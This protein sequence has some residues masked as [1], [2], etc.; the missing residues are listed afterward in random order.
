MQRP[1]LYRSALDFRSLTVASLGALLL[2]ACGEPPLDSPAGT[3][4][5]MTAA[6]LAAEQ[7]VDREAICAPDS[8]EL[9]LH[10]PSPD[11]GEQVVYM[12]F[13]DRFNDGD[14]TN[15]DFGEGEFDPTSPSHFN[16]GDI[17]GIIDQLDYIQGMGATAIWITPPVRN[18]WWSTPYRA[19]GWH[20]YWAQHFKEMDP[21]FGTLEEYQRLSHE[22]HCRGMYLVQDIVI[23]HVGNYYAYD[24]EWNPDDPTENFYLIEE[25]VTEPTAPTQEPFNLI[26]P[27]IPEH[28]EADIYHWTPQVTDYDDPYQL[29]YFGF[30]FLA[31][32]NT[33]NTVV[34]EAFKDSYNY[35]IREVGVDGF[36][37]DTV[38]YVKQP[39]WHHFL[40]DE[41]GV[42]AAAAETGREFFI[43]FGETMMASEP[44]QTEGEDRNAYFMDYEG[45][46]GLNSMLGFPLYFSQRRV[47]SEGQPAAQL[48]FRLEKHMTAYPDPRVIPTFIDNHDTARFIAT[49]GIEAFRQALVLVYT[50][51]GLP[52]I[53]M[54]TEQK[55]AETRH[56]MFAEGWGAQGDNFATDS[57]GYTLL[58]TLGGLRASDPLFTD[59]ELAV[60][61]GETA[62]PGLLAYRRDFDGRQV[63]VLMNSADHGILVHELETGLPAETRLEALWA[64]GAIDTVATGRDGLLSLELPARAA[65][66]LRPA[67]PAETIAA[68]V[69]VTPIA[70]DDAP[71]DQLLTADTTLTGTA[72]PDT[73]LKVIPD[74]NLDKATRVTT[75]SEGRF[76]LILPVRDL[77]EA[78]RSVQLRDPTAGTVSERITYRT[79][80]SSPTLDET[81]DDAT[82]EGLGPEGRYVI[83][84]H[85]ESRRQR[86]IESI[87]VRAAGRN[88]E[89]ELTM[90]EVSTPWSPI[91]GFD[92]VAVT[93]FIGFPDQAGATVLPLLNAHMPEGTHWNLAHATSGW[94]SYVYREE[95][96]SADHQGARQ[97]FAPRVQGDTAARTIT[98]FLE[99]ARLGVDDWSG[100]TLYVTTWDMNGEGGYIEIL[101]E[102][103]NW[104]FGGGQP[105]DPKIADALL[106]TLPAVGGP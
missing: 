44:F 84:Q 28:R 27:R 72:A 22:L 3:A 6:G 16:G 5:T 90:A 71:A 48:A 13:I 89:L 57:D 11:W 60:L 32:V 85:S 17:Q 69:D 29:N 98:L 80:V 61:A 54:G 63:L 1:V 7:P 20:G 55:M 102:P 41:N 70:F 9:L 97:G 45:L 23:N 21:H 24:G 88:L 103:S 87:R 100:A 15:N 31:D 82:G 65:W 59:G 96:A 104:A 46:P 67:G 93:T 83:P 92:N 94:L 10:V 2:T 62:G 12:M 47:L 78:E 51:P 37:I 19:A 14:P 106:V 73:M 30:G 40:H 4:D 18:Q 43:T 39:F 42:Y 105:G 50:I 49:A 81:F 8:D 56:A 86:E 58:Q 34:L 75:D 66:V 52:I 36:R 76:S 26:D 35:W 91:N 25:G 79:R 64:Q 101:E 33:E 99:G 95:G 77:G 38:Q 74:G 68:A 53:Y